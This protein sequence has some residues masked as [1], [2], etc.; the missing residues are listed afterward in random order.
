MVNNLCLW[1]QQHYTIQHN[2]TQHNTTQHNNTRGNETDRGYIIRP[3][4]LIKR[5]FGA[6]FLRCLAAYGHIK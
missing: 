3:L 6:L 2:T 4:P 1:S 5:G